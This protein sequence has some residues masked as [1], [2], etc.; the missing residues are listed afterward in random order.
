MCAS[1]YWL[2]VNGWLILWNK[3]STPLIFFDDSKCPITSSSVIKLYEDF[4][5]NVV[6]AN[7]VEESHA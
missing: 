5:K 2:R 7:D 6:R 4:G 1:G 3:E